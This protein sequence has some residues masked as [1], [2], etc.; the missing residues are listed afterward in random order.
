MVA[1]THVT[2]LI[3]DGGAGRLGVALTGVSSIFD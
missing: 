2:V 1:T 3:V